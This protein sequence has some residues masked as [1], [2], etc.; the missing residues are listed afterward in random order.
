MVNYKVA[1]EK[2]A[3]KGKEAM[4][5]AESKMPVTAIT[6]RERFAKEKPLEGITIAG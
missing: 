4:Y 5:I 2:L 6:I 3:V 1:D